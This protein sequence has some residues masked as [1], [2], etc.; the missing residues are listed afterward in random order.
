MEKGKTMLN[1]A[2][3][4]WFE[5]QFSTIKEAKSLVGGITTSIYRI[6]T[7]DDLTYILRIYDH[8]GM[9]E[10]EPDI[11]HHEVAALKAAKEAKLNS[12]AFICYEPDASV[13]GYPLL[14]MEALEGTVN[15]KPSDMSDWLKQS[16]E[17]LTAIHR[18][19][20]QEFGWNYFR[21]FDAENTP[22]PLWTRYPQNWQRALEIL[23]SPAPETPRCFIHRD[24]H[25]AN[26]LWQ[27]GQLSGIVDWPNACMGTANFDLA[28]MRVNL[29]SLYG[30]PVA[31]E[32]LAQYQQLNPDFVYQP[33]WDLVGVGDFYLAGDEAPEVYNPWI[34]LGM[35][36][37]TSELMAERAEDYLISVLKSF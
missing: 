1:Q 10:E 34:D 20:I 14:V 3:Q 37:L 4:N 32:F 18:A 12:P 17:A 23:K 29:V 2:I 13:A 36:E 21:Y 22:V 16:A 11:P 27:N 26:I 9:L 28:H 15:L 6:Q 24:F 8:E 35:T 5:K 30:I 33:Y 7:K 31:D 19:P 25:P